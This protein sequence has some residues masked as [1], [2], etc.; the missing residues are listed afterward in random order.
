MIAPKPQAEARRM[1]TDTKQQPLPPETCS[2]TL[3]QTLKWNLWWCGPLHGAI[4]WY[5]RRCA[6]AFHHMQYGP[7]GKYVVLMSDEQYH[8]YGKMR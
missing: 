7:D 6:G 4:C 8:R 5:L 2:A 1:S 3:L